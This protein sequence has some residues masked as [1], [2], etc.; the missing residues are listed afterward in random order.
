MHN[1]FIC[2][3]LNILI[4]SNHVHKLFNV[5]LEGHTLVHIMFKIRM[6]NKQYGIS[7]EVVTPKL[8]SCLLFLVFIF[9]NNLSTWLTR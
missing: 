6:K 9:I 4:S 3:G 7:F 5:K 8:S 2:F 1:L